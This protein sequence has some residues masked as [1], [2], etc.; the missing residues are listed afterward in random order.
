[1]RVLLL[2]QWQQKPSFSEKLF[3]QLQI[4]AGGRVGEHA[5]G[6][7]RDHALLYV[8]VWVIII[9]DGEAEAE[10]LVPFWIDAENAPGDGYCDEVSI[11]LQ[12]GG[13]L[14]IL[15]PPFECGWV[16]QLW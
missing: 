6:H 11:V 16:P 7:I 4:T 2:W 10:V 3:N 9:R 12:A 8:F 5:N 14:H 1:M 13:D 15:L